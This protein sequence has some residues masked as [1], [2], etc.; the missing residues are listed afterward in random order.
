MV[1]ATG[2]ISPAE[3]FALFEEATKLGIRK[4]LV[5]HPLDPEF[6]DQVPSMDEIKRL[7]AMGAIIE[8]TFVCHLPTEFSRNPKHTAAA[9]KEIGAEHCI[10][11]TDLGLFMYNPPPVEGMRMFIASLMRN[12][13]TDKEI[14]LMAKVNP[15]KL[16]GLD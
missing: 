2:H 3:I 8:L 13:I 14:E 1:L 4:L 11:S 12:G 7:V 10:I 16:L 5:T 9:I 6:S 15:S